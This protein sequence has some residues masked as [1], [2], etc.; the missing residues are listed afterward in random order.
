MYNQGVQGLCY[1]PWKGGERV[2]TRQASEFRSSCYLSLSS[3][4][5]W[6]I[7]FAME[8]SLAFS[9]RMSGECQSAV[10]ICK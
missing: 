6:E 10:S 9:Y 8:L 2:L 3:E 7:C 5:L 4:D 1:G